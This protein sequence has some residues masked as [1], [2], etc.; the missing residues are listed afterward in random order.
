MLSSKREKTPTCLPSRSTSSAW[1]EGARIRVIL[2]LGSSSKVSDIGGEPFQHITIRRTHRLQCVRRL[3]LETFSAA[4]HQYQCRKMQ[5]PWSARLGPGNAS[6]SSCRNSMHNKK[7]GITVFE[8]PD[9]IGPS[10]KRARCS[11]NWQSNLI[12]SSHSSYK[13]HI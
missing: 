7:L 4:E 1:N 10:L 13:W 2:N 6:L 8:R 12:L 3:T 11:Q 9:D 5:L